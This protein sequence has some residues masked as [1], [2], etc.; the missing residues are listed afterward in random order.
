MA[1]AIGIRGNKVIAVPFDEA[2][3]AKKTF[4]EKNDNQK[5]YVTKIRRVLNS[6]L[7]I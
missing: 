6:P 5:A 3:S 4:N 2:F 1:S 7:F